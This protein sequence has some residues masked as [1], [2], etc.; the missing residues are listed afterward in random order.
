M[1]GIEPPPH[2]DGRSLLGEAPA[3]TDRSLFVEFDPGAVLR[4]VVGAR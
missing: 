2:F 3:R 1:T 4:R